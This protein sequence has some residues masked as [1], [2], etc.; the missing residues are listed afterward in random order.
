[1]MLNIT[2]AIKEASK[3][4]TMLIATH[5]ENILDAFEVEHVR[6]FQKEKDNSTT[7]STFRAD[8][9]T[10]WYDEYNLGKMWRKG[11]IGGNR[12]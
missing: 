12:W 9:F 3:N 5:S 6:V 1:M 7:V 10:N 4:S 8:D 2:N 11:D